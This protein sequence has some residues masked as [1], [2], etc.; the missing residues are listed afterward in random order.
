MD[1]SW[2]KRNSMME[3][4]VL[5]AVSPDGSVTRW[6]SVNPGTFER[7]VLNPAGQFMTVDCSEIN[8]TFA[9]AGNFK[10]VDLYDVETFKLMQTVG[11]GQ[12]GNKILTLRYFPNSWRQMV[13]GGWDCVKLWDIR[14]MGR[15]AEL[16]GT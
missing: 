11:K 14:S 16:A 3:P 15:T 10:Q 6:S 7:A 13:T 5:V 2:R 8:R 1:M 12:I 4:H 9:V